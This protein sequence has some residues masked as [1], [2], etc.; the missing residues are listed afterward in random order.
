MDPA[1]FILC[2]N[3]AVTTLL[4]KCFL[5]IWLLCHSGLSLWWHITHL[6]CL[7]NILMCCSKQ[8]THLMFWSCG[9]VGGKSL[10]VNLLLWT[11]QIYSNTTLFLLILFKGQRMVFFWGPWKFFYAVIDTSERKTIHFSLLLSSFPLFIFKGFVRMLTVCY[12]T[13]QNLFLDILNRGS[14][15]LSTLIGPHSIK[16]SLRRATSHKYSS[17]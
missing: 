9:C 16:L 14:F 6:P 10:F 11:L 5:L 8:Q 1:Q 12:E 17:S 4:Q 2:L 15:N 13:W 7:L 3:A